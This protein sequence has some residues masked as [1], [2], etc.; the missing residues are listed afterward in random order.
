MRP[1]C[2][3]VGWAWAFFYAYITI[4]VIVLLNLVTAVMVDNAMKNSQKEEQQ[5]LEL[6]EKEKAKQLEQFRSLFELMDT[7]GSGTLTWCEFESAFEVTEVAN[8]L[9]LLDFEAKDCRELFALLDNGNGE[10]SLEE[11]FEGISNMDGTAKAK[12]SFKLLKLAD[13]L[14]RSL[15]QFAH[16][17]QEDNIDLLEYR[18]DSAVHTRIGSLRSRARP[19]LTGSSLVSPP[20]SSSPSP[21]KV[22]VLE[23]GLPAAGIEPSVN[24]GSTPT[25]RFVFPRP[26][27]RSHSSS[28]AG[29]PLKR[30]NE[31]SSQVFACNDKV[32]ILANSMCSLQASMALVLQKLDCQGQHPSATPHMSLS[33]EKGATGNEFHMPCELKS[34]QTR[35][36]SDI[37]LERIDV[38]SERTLELPPSSAHLQCSLPCLL[39]QQ[40]RN[41]QA[42]WE[43][44]KEFQKHEAQILGA[45]DSL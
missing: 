40:Q 29:T 3:Y 17:A 4:A 16:D 26:L 19:N 35:E 1:M 6:K 45:K 28:D 27:Q 30:L 33:V 5:L 24:E 36:H 34:A 15:Q 2:N 44:H 14:Q 41:P 38:P 22:S 37:L 42:G 11:F 32:D 10:L 8:K 39:P 9:R 23:P 7:D 12:D 43:Q 21:R 25:G 20:K 13:T 18:P 31:V